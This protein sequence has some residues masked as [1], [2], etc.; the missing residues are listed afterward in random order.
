MATG[1]RDAY[2]VAINSRGFLLR[3][4]PNAPAYVKELAP[5]LVNQLGIGDLNY[6]SLN[7]S[8]WSYWTQTDWAGGFQRLKFKDDASFK[9][10]QGVDVI[11]K[12]GEVSLQYGWT[13]AVSISGSHSYGAHATHDRDMLFGTVKNAGA[14]VFKV[15][16][17]F[18]ISTLSAMTTISAINSITHFGSN[19]I[20]GMTKQTA[21][22][23]SVKSMAKYTGGSTISG[24]RAA[25]PIVRAVKGIGVRLYSGERVR[26]LSGDVLYYSTDLSTF[27]SA[28][29]A[30]KN[31]EIKFIDD[32]N[33]DPY[34]FIVEGR[35]VEF[36]RWD[37]IAERAYP[38]YKW[39]D[40]TN[41][42]VHKY[43]TQFVIAGT[44]ANERV[45]YSFNGAR[46]VQIFDDQLKDSSYD[47]RYPFEFEGHYHNFG[48]TWDGSYWF[49]GIYG[50]V[51]SSRVVP[52]GNFAN[53]AVGMITGS[54]MRI[55][56]QDRTKYAVSGH[57]ISSE[58]GANIAGVDKLLNTVNINMNALATGQTIEVLRSTDGGATFTSIGKAAYT[59]GGALTKKQLYFPSGYVTKLWNYK[60]QLVG[61][62]TSTPTLNDITFEYRP[63]PDTKHRWQLALD[64]S[65][66]QY[67]LNKQR[68]QR[69]GKALVEELW[70][71][72]E[73]KRTII[74]EDVNSFEVSIVS[75]MTSANTSA[76]V[77][78]VARMPMRGRI[79]VYKANQVEEMTY[80]SADGNKV[81]GLVRGLKG[82]QARAYTSADKFDN[83][84]SVVVTS[85]AEQLN[86]TD[87]LKTESIARVTLLE[88]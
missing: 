56:Y 10:G 15:T 71:E 21:A 82:T 77:N 12:Y 7:G 8:G 78:S 48:A 28:F 30:G 18:S 39:E 47:F 74:F 1:V 29:Q 58:F 50:K 75:A 32:L 66:E 79:R 31:R 67:L 13:S 43:L 3:G 72:K 46:L 88:V 19:S 80:T 38:I 68:M 25:N 33:G 65:N 60:V 57:I 36:F 85:V 61:P 11:R 55:A 49:P 27:T 20:I 5:S 86:W 42:S 14:K 37:E 34:F 24:F 64:A 76:R 81:A 45:A 23:A 54:T 26:S 2:H 52:I 84:Y 83:Y 4:T 44:T 41:F 87:Q 53:K 69:D 73:A 51:G 22:S 16:S 59:S 17:A 63:T 62:G 6:N 40:L 70:L 9:D 35:R